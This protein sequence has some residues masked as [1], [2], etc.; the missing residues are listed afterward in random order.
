MQFLVLGRERVDNDAE[1]VDFVLGRGVGLSQALDLGFGVAQI[2]PQARDQLAELVRLAFGA[3]QF[4]LARREVALRSL[5]VVGEG[6][7]GRVV[8]LPPQ[9]FEFGPFGFE[10]RLR[11]G[12]RGLEFFDPGV[13]ALL[14]FVR[15]VCGWVAGLGLSVGKKCART[16]RQSARGLTDRLLE[17]A[18]LLLERRF[19]FLMPRP[20]LARV[21]NFLLELVPDLFELVLERTDF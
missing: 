11:F 14:G 13:R 7:S 18:D 20:S 8:F 1:L 19:D 10:R 17:R 5:Q 15:R 16:E 12:E 9:A 21:A 4:R 6:R 3:F 2:L